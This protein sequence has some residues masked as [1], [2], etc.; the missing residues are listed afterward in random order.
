MLISS[1]SPLFLLQLLSLFAT[2]T[3]GYRTC[4]FQHIGAGAL[5][6]SLD[7]D[8]GVQDVSLPVHWCWRARRVDVHSLG[9]CAHFF[10]LPC[11]FLPSCDVYHGVQDVL[12]L[13]HWRWH[14]RRVTQ[15]GPW[16]PGWVIASTSVLTCLSRRCSFPARTS[17]T[18]AWCTTPASRSL[19]SPV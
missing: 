12:L 14:S 4:C 5:V 8:H 7:V 1:L 18:R 13:A 16:G 9:S 6:A 19:S 3:M 10:H 17:S 2:C 15:R 11:C